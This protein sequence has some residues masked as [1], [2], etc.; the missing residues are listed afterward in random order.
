VGSSAPEDPTRLAAAVAG[1]LEALADPDRAAAMRAYMRHQFPF[2]GVGTPE[3]RRASKPLVAASRRWPS[4]D[5]VA[6]VDHLWSRP[7]REFRYVGCDVARAAAR[8]WESERLADLR[9]WVT[10]DS[11]WDTV[12]SLAVSVG[13]LVTAHPELA[14]EMDGWIADQDIWVARVALL[15]QLGW[16]DRVDVDRLFGYCAA[17][18]SDTEF[19]VRKAIGWALRDAARTFPEEVRGFVADHPE[20][21]GLSRREALKH[22]GW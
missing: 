10:S 22:L 8:R 12:D 11:W 14:A 5:A 16:K 6:V 3:R 20:L 18:A 2:L 19:F 1:D 17:R 7:E 21:S 13:D 9:R 15:H 4:V